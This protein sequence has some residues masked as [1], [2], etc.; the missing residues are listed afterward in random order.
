MRSWAE[1]RVAIIGLCAVSMCGCSASD[2]GRLARS[3]ASADTL[4]LFVAAS[5]T[6]P[7]QPL[8]DTFVAR[9]QGTPAVIQRESGGSLEHARKLTE[10]RRIP[11]V[12]L[13]ADEEVFPQLLVPSQTPWYAD[14]AR[15][16]MVVAYTERSRHAAQI[17]STNWTRILSS[18]DVQVGRCDPDVAPVGYRTILMM[19]LAGK[20]THDPA[21]ADRLLTNAPHR[22]MRPNAA[23]LAALLEAGELD[24]IYDYESVAIANGFRYVELAP[25]IDLSDLRFASSY[26]SETLKVRGSKVGDS[27]IVTGKPILYA[28]SVPR[29]APHPAAAARFVSLLLSDEGRRI[30]RAQHVD[31]LDTPRFF[32]DSVPAA[33]RDLGRP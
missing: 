26:A 33:I 19:R 1:V 20:R 5:L 9:A 15:N 32:G 11:D 16:R 3:P 4:V 24:Y 2:D 29:A 6:K 21:L 23:E 18:P 7:M 14:F 10:L 31:M 27:T 13:L 25:E 28:L 30:L 22:N 12:I 17:D 8:L